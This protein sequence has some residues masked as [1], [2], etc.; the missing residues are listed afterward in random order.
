M[1]ATA[2]NALASPKRPDAIAREVTDDGAE[3]R[4]V[5][6]ATPELLGEA[7]CQYL[8]RFPTKRLPR[9]GGV[10]VTVVV[11]M[12]LD[13]LLTGLGVAS[14]DT[15]GHLSAGQARRLACQAGVIPMVLGSKSQVLDQGRRVRLHTESQRIAMRVRDKGCTAVGCTIPAA[16]CHAHHDVPWSKGG[17]TSVKE[18]RM[19][20]P[21][22]HRMVHHPDYA[23]QPAP[24]GALRITKIARNRP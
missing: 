15:G 8:E 18:G 22:H 13:T 16:W 19:L 20:C 5:Q 12:T 14:L 7:F 21:R 23:T 17:R 9:A 10:G 3:S 2:L 6:R 4:V 24:D 11:T 1:L